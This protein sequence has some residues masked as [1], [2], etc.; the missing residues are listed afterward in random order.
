MSARRK[1]SRWLTFYI[2][3]L[4]AGLA[5]CLTP[6]TVLAQGG[7]PESSGCR[8]VESSCSTCH[9]QSDPVSNQ[10][11]WHTVHAP[12]D[13][14]RNCH[15]GNDQTMDEDQAH[16][17]LVS[18]PLDDT[19][20]SCHQ[21]H[22]DDYQRRADHFATQL[23]IT[24]KSNVP[25]TTTAAI[26]PLSNEPKAQLPGTNLPGAGAKSVPWLWV[27]VALMVTLTSTL[28]VQWSRRAH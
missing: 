1:S 4:A 6:A 20:L 8:L 13:A 17:G 2:I 19:Y 9:A 27:L 15:G 21:C 11:E 10:G 25:V 12:E 28:I 5:L 16:V 26:Q 22:P 7:G 24:A 23:G 18:N 3:T 14:C